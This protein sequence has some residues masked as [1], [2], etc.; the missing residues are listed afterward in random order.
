MR[1]ANKTMSKN[2][3]KFGDGKNKTFVK[4]ITVSNS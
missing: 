1:R 2:I 4:I 3:E